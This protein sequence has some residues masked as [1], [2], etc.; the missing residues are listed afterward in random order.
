MVAGRQAVRE[1]LR[2]RRRAV[3]RLWLADGLDERTQ[4]MA[5]I[6]TLAADQGIPLRRVP[7]AQLDRRAGTDAPQGVLAQAERVPVFQLDQ[8]TASRD[9]A[10]FLLVLDGVTDPHNVGALLRSALGAGATGAVIGKHRAA[11]LT[12]AVLKAAAGAV[13][14]LPLAVVAGI[15]AALHRLQQEGIWTIGLAGD[16]TE[17]L[18]DLAVADDAL[19]LVVG[20]EGQGLATLTRQRCQLLIS[21]PMV[22]PID[23]LNVATAGALACFEVAR[24]RRGTQPPA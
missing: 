8:L 14:Y 9:P 2:A 23:S 12:P 24:R 3:H 11:P 13:E 1:L 10:P 6:L 21:I 7:R 5:E 16:A 22:G 17:S 4:P 18:W 15:P 19:A 20:A